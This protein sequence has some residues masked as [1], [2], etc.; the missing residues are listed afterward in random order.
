MNCEVAVSYKT[1]DIHV[2]IGTGGCGFLE[3]C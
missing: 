2:E 3:D 1:S